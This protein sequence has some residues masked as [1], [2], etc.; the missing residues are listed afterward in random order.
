MSSAAA[1]D[2]AFL[3]PAK[4]DSQLTKPMSVVAV[5]HWTKYVKKDVSVIF[6]KHV[7]NWSEG[8]DGNV[9]I[10]QKLDRP[11]VGY[12]K[13]LIHLPVAC[14][15]FMCD[16]SHFSGAKKPWLKKPPKD[17]SEE[18]KLVDA[19]HLW[20]YYLKKVDHEMN[21]GLDF[22]NWKKGQRPCKLHSAIRIV[23]MVQLVS[24]RISLSLSQPSD[25]TPLTGT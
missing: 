24:H 12:S 5:Y 8:S 13:P 7:T 3:D 6:Q 9:R 16:F 4:T 11:F 22:D 20:W 18:T 19:P 1:D 15:K 23:Y 17:L 14:Q 21:M 10:E 25:F 2:P